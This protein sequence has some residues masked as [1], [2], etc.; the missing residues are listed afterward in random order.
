MQEC[1]PDVACSY[2]CYRVCGRETLKRF[3][4]WAKGRGA[5]AI[6]LYTTE[7]ALPVWRDSWGFRE[8]ETLL[9]KDG[10]IKYGPSMSGIV[11]PRHV[12]R[13]TE[14]VSKAVLISNDIDYALKNLL[15]K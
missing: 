10:I 15:Q 6:R 9:E 7:R 11:S 14:E 4:N 13:R 8:S 12:G 1:V 3:F 5:K 2:Y